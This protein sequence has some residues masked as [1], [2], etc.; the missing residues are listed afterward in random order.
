MRYAKEIK[1]AKE[2]NPMLPIMKYYEGSGKQSL[3]QLVSNLIRIENEYGKKK[4]LS[5]TELVK[6]IGELGRTTTKELVVECVKYSARNLRIEGNQIFVWR[7][8]K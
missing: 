5:P 4:S 2:A 6:W 8:R 7:P 3:E 1:A